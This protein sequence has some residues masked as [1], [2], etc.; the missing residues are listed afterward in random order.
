MPAATLPK[1]DVILGE[2]RK[3]RVQAA[4]RVGGS[5]ACAEDDDER[6]TDDGERCGSD[7]EVSRWKPTLKKPLSAPLI[8]TFS[9]LLY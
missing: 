9:P 1:Y 8:C 2:S 5:P 3:S 7:K 4:L 6:K